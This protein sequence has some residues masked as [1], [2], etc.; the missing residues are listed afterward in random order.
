MTWSSDDERET[1]KVNEE[2]NTNKSSYIRQLSDKSSAK[3]STGITNSKTTNLVIDESKEDRNMVQNH[4]NSKRATLLLE[5]PESASKKRRISPQP[6]SSRSSS[7]SVSP[8]SPPPPPPRATTKPYTLGV[9]QIQTPTRN[10]SVPSRP[11]IVDRDEEGHYL[12]EAYLEK[13]KWLE[14]LKKPRPSMPLNLAKK[15]PS[16]A[17]QDLKSLKSKETAML[18]SNKN[19]SRQI[20]DGPTTSL[21]QTIN[22]AKQQQQARLLAIYEKQQEMEKQR[23]EEEKRAEKESVKAPKPWPKVPNPV[24]STNNPPIQKSHSVEATSTNRVENQVKP[25]PAPKPTKENSNSAKPQPSSSGADK[26]DI[27]GNIMNIQNKGNTRPVEQRKPSSHSNK[28]IIDHFL[29]R[30][31]RCTYN[32]LVE[33]GLILDFYL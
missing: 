18:F 15:G 25:K 11:K 17:L 27:L 31:L 12:S 3:P 26:N 33:Q 6:K 19:K 22:I 23:F 13:K 21:T 4:L 9:R 16:K 14:Q 24:Q 20:Y 32:W 1:P 5:N 30:L 2:K 8:P 10:D 7:S 29:Y 28:Y